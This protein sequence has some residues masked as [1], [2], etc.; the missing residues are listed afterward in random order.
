M[1]LFE[2]I[3]NFILII[4]T[5]YM[6]INNIDSI[7]SIICVLLFMILIHDSH[8]IYYQQSFTNQI[9]IKH[10]TFVSTA[11]IFMIILALIN[12]NY[13]ILILLITHFFI[14]NIRRFFI[15]RRRRSNI[16]TYVMQSPIILTSSSSISDTECSICL[17]NY[18]S[19]QRI[20]MLSCTHKFHYD[21]IN[22]WIQTKA[23][24]PL[25]NTRV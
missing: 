11:L 6:F 14:S 13:N 16:E 10:I 20:G 9:I 2:L 1:S 7:I 4:L 23:I 15:I 8:F 17:E 3:I 19:S 24:C 21:C 18:N 12:Q 22:S 25:C 5:C